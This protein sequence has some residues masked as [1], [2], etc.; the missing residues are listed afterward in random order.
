MMAQREPRILL[1]HCRADRDSASLMRYG[2]PS[3]LAYIAAFLR[4]HTD[5]QV[6]VFD[7]VCSL[8]D[9]LQCEN[10]MRSEDFDL[11]GFTVYQ[12]NLSVCLSLAS[13][14]KKIKPNAYIV[15]GGPQ[16]TLDAKAILQDNE[17]IDMVVSGEGEFTMKQIALAL[18]EGRE[19]KDIPGTVMRHNGSI[20]RIPSGAQVDLDALPFPSWEI[21]SSSLAATGIL[22]VQTSRG[23]PFSCRFC[24]NEAIYSG[25]GRKWRAR[26]VE[27]VLE[28][29]R[30][31]ASHCEV[32]H[33]RFNDANFLVGMNF[34]TI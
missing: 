25:S 28:E 24:C 22:D 1:L 17:Q 18:A 3:G 7:D 15:F 29:I 12:K 6:K 16:A 8:T 31:A 2:Y 5:A 21:V 34:L 32:R 20:K 11:V 10:A 30:F 19:L 13:I 9:E 4:K 23:C 26:S 27:N 33:V 14:S